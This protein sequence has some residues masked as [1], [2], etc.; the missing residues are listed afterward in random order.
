MREFNKFDRG[1]FSASGKH[2]KVRRAESLKGGG[3]DH[4][5]S[6]SSGGDHPHVIFAD[7]IT[8]DDQK[9][10]PGALGEGDLEDLE[11]I[12]QV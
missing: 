4:P 5:H 2:G 9:F 6:S 1:F 8:D 3:G 10:S 7:E 12:L 11:G